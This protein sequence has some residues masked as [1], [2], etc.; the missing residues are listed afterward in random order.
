MAAPRKPSRRSTRGNRQTSEPPPSSRAP[1]MGGTQEFTPWNPAAGQNDMSMAEYAARHQGIRNPG[2]LRDRYQAA[3][4][5]TGGRAFQQ[6]H[7]GDV[8]GDIAQGRI[9]IIPEAVP[10]AAP[11]TPVDPGFKRPTLPASGAQ[12]GPMSDRIAQI[13]GQRGPDAPPR[14]LGAAGNLP[15]GPDISY[16]Q[17]L[18]GRGSTAMLAGLYR[19]MTG[20]QVTPKMRQAMLAG[21]QATSGLNQRFDRQEAKALRNAKRRR[22]PIIEE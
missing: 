3:T 4:S 9:K 5:E 21:A 15:A 20:G 22:Q 1:A 7:E 2:M 13:I 14:Q 16:K 19:E 6:R 11:S 8:A 18:N 17:Y 10:G 12:T